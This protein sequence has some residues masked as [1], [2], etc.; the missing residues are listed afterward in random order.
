[1]EFINLRSRLFFKNCRGLRSRLR[2]EDEQFLDFIE[3]ILKVISKRG[4]RN[5]LVININDSVSVVKRAEHGVWNY[6]TRRK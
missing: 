4:V 2:T 3:K 1:M 5:K 6:Q